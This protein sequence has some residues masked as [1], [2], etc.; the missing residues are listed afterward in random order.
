[1]RTANDK[2]KRLKGA[3]PLLPGGC[4]PNALNKPNV[5]A[6]PLLPEGVPPVPESGGTGT[7]FFAFGSVLILR[8]GIVLKRR[9]KAV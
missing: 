7:A 2:G 9:K 4:C 8:A 3:F 6:F 1:M 5:A